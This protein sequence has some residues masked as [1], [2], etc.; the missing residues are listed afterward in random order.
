M[1]AKTLWRQ[2]R[3]PDRTFHFVSNRSFC[4]TCAIIL[5]ERCPYWDKTSALLDIMHIISIFHRIY[6]IWTQVIL[7]APARLSHRVCGHQIQIIKWTELQMPL[8]SC[9]ELC[10][11]PPSKSFFFLTTVG[12]EKR[13]RRFHEK[14]PTYIS[15]DGACIQLRERQNMTSLLWW[16]TDLDWQW[17]TV[18]G[19]TSCMSCHVSFS[20]QSVEDSLSK[21]T[22]SFCHRRFS[23]RLYVLLRQVRPGLTDHLKMG[24]IYFFKYLLLQ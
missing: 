22:W 18:V 20:R 11:T 1:I 2:W 23:P 9:N 24:K 12:R 4:L 14:T 7:K 3:C 15:H 16:N 21:T 6:T 13:S 8:R 17:T 5:S 10:S 19:H